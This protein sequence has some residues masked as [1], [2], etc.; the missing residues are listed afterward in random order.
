MFSK[1]L[2]FFFL[3]ELS[4]KTNLI[5]FLFYEILLFYI[6]LHTFDM[7]NHELLCA[8]LKY[9]NFNE[10][11]ISLVN[12]FLSNRSQCVTINGI[13]SDSINVIHA[14]PR[15]S[16]L[17][18]L[19]FIIYTSDFHHVLNNL[20]LHAYADD[21]NLYYTSN[22]NELV[23][24]EGPVNE[25]IKDLVKISKN[26]CLSINPGKSSVI[27][28]GRIKDRQRAIDNILLQVDLHY[29]HYADKI[30]CLGLIIDSKFTI[31]QSY[32]FT[33]L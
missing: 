21:I 32:K 1:E 2:K 5:Y 12:S 4:V 6:Y 8:K 16:I 11:T 24:I 25:D 18:P 20:S 3:A 15:G 28:F 23:N 22:I 17:A 19:L 7:M 33:H 9:F 26:H 27:V 10:N 13:T 30:K 29:L 14:A 31:C